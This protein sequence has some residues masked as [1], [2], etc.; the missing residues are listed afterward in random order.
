[1]AATPKQA[2]ALSSYFVKKYKEKYGYD[3]RFNRNKARWSWD[4]MLMDMTPT[5]AKSL[6]DYYFTT[7]NPQN[8]PLE[9]FFYNY[10]KLEEAK[11]KMEEDQRR[12]E[13]IRAESAKRAEEWRKKKNGQ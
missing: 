4:N 2:H 5:E 12:L 10:D 6:V 13:V 11:A 3:H 7:I 9:W 8:H 1:M